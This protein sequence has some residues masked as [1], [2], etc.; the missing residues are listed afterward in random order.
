MHSPRGPLRAGIGWPLA[1]T[2]ALLL[3]LAAAARDQ[4]PTSTML[5]GSASAS[6]ELQGLAA[7]LGLAVAVPGP[8]NPFRDANATSKGAKDRL[9]RPAAPG[10]AGVGAKEGS[11]PAAQPRLGA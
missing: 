2:L 7:A 3:V 10:A 4:R 6:A 9:P 5:M 8:A 1:M 11:S